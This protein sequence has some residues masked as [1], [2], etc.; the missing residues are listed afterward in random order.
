MGQ[1]AHVFAGAKHTEVHAKVLMP[2]KLPL[3]AHL[4]DPRTKRWGKLVKVRGRKE[5][6]DL[7]LP[8][9]PTVYRVRAL[10]VST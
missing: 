4:Y 10:L 6:I 2:S 9:V 5:V 8:Q 3:G 7:S 1:I